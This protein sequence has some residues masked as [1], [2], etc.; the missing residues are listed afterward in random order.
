MRELQAAARAALDR[1]HTL[2]QRYGTAFH[3][4]PPVSDVRDLKPLVR[5]KQVTS[6]HTEEFDKLPQKY[7]QRITAVDLTDVYTAWQLANMEM[8]PVRI[9]WVKPGQELNVSLAAGGL[10]WLFIGQGAKVT[11][12]Q[13]LVDEAV[14][15]SRL[16]VW[17]EER[18]H[19]SFIG[20]RAN[21]TFLNEKI[22]V[23]LA[24]SEATTKV[25][26]LTY[27]QDQAQTDIGVQ[28]FHQAPR[29]RSNL[30]ARA[31]AADQTRAIYRGLIDV[32]Q[33]A[34]ATEGYQSARCLLLSRKAVIDA[35][36]E[37]AIRTNDVR[38]SHGVTTT[39][40]NDL[41]LFYLRSRG[42]SVD[43]ARAQALRGFFHHQLNIPNA[44]ALR[45]DDLMLP[46]TVKADVNAN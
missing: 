24:G 40:L 15:V 42:L 12:D 17:Q 3:I 16:F 29:T 38:C 19:M 32:D 30:F 7:Q 46:V 21:L 9:I 39:H 28:V 26:H 25:T 41:S 31:A 20:L 14:L 4:S 5:D 22:E 11:I 43:Q 37:L 45:L 33:S 18:S 8:S 34:L 1:N 2:P 6:V 36:P 27:G 13:S 44:M 35:L 23:H 10:D